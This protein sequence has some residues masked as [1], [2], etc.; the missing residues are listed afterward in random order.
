MSLDDFQNKYT[1][2]YEP[3]KVSEYNYYC[4]SSGKGVKGL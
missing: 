3:D 2:V 1:M 4:Y